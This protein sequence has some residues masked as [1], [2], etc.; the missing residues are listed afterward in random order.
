MPKRVYVP[1]SLL[2]YGRI[3]GEEESPRYVI[4]MRSPVPRWQQLADQLR[5]EIE[6]GTLAPDDPIPSETVLEQE[7]GLARGTI[8]KV[9]TALR[10]EGLVVTVRGKGSYVTGPESRED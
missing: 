8:R 1:L 7:T 6:S 5:A 2:T 3:M 10:D 4:N 9:I